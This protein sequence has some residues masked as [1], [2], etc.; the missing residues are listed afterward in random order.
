VKVSGLAKIKTFIQMSG[1]CLVIGSP[2]TTLSYFNEASLSILLIGV[3]IGFYS[4]FKYFYKSK[5][6]LT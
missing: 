1:I 4:A 5:K 6:Y 3:I 2:L